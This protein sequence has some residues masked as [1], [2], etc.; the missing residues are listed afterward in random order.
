MR[1]VVATFNF[2]GFLLLVLSFLQLVLSLLIKNLY[3]YQSFIFYDIFLYDAGKHRKINAVRIEL[4][5]LGS[6]VLV[7][8]CISLAWLKC[9]GM[10]S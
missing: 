9:K 5:F 3:F 7:L 4:S 6:G 10:F 2:S 8:I 1:Q